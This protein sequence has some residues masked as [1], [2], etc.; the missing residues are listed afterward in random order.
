MLA[1]AVSRRLVALALSLLLLVTQQW[2]ML[3]VLSHP[4][5]PTGADA[6]LTI[7]ASDGATDLGAGPEA[8]HDA[9]PH[10]A[11]HADAGDALCQVCLVLATLGVAGL[12]ALWRWMP[13]LLRAAAPRLPAQPAPLRRA[14]APWLARGPPVL[15]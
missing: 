7:S 15:R 6:A 11:A 13:G 5:H 10:S 12:P 8:D 1:P 4:L 2:G 14:P 3:H 9:E